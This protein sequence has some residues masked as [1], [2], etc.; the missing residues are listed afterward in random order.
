MNAK[1]SKVVATWANDAGDSAEVIYS[2]DGAHAEDSW[3]G[4]EH[5]L[6]PRREVQLNLLLDSGQQVVLPFTGIAKILPDKS[7]V[8]AIFD[9]GQYVNPDGTDHFPY[10][11]NA[12]IYNADG[13]LRF[14]LIVP[15]VGVHRI[16]GFHG[17]G[18]PEKYK[19]CIGVVIATHSNAP[20]EWVYAVDP[21]SP[22]LISTRAWTRW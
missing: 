11:N 18:M 13:S 6:P 15:R 3:D 9:P 21:N 12:A 14:Q 7:G 8:V 10:P 22:T 4:V 16:G 20:P 5:I 19:D 17:G 1:I 2:G